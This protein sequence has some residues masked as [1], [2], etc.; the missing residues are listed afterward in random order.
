[1]CS[2]NM[3]SLS[4]KKYWLIDLLID[5][6]HLKTK[7]T[8]LS[9]AIFNVNDPLHPQK[10][11]AMYHSIADHV[12]IHGSEVA[13]MTA[14]SAQTSQLRNIPLSRSHSSVKSFQI[15]KYTN[16]S[17]RLF[18]YYPT[19]ELYQ[20]DPELKLRRPTP[21]S[22]K[23]QLQMHH[24]RLAVAF[25]GHFTYRIKMKDFVLYNICAVVEGIPN[26][27]LLCPRYSDQTSSTQRKRKRRASIE[28]FEQ[29]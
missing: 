21:I 2:C 27:L 19:E 11:T 9:E 5:W 24:H 23:H 17:L 18:K 15:R 29:T 25:I 28:D 3:C 22:L 14:I 12:R 8:L 13:Y 6:S 4:D 1:M 26:V 20:L 16:E 7:N 10:H